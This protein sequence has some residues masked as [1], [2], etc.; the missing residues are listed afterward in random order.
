MSAWFGAVFPCVDVS[1]TDGE[2][3]VVS[4]PPV[5]LSTSF[6]ENGSVFMRRGS[7]AVPASSGDSSA[8]EDPCSLDSKITSSFSPGGDLFF[9]D[10]GLSVAAASVC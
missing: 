6:I 2:E 5:A 9:F 8:D 1:G 3:L 7:A 10:R 4:V